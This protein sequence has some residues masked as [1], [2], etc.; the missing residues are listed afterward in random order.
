MKLNRYI[1]AQVRFWVRVSKSEGCWNWTGR[2]DQDGY[3]RLKVGGKDY[4]AHVYSYTLH[5]GAVP[6]GL[7]VLHKCDNRRCVRPDHLFLGTQE[8]NAADRVSKGRSA[9]GDRNAS[10]KYPERRPRGERHHWQT[11]PETRIR[12][13][14]NGRAKLTDSRVALIRSI[15][16]A[17]QH[18]KRGLGRMFGVSDTLINKIITNK[19]WTHL[20]GG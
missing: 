14:A 5:Y 10:R 6:A 11:K 12:G 18:T 9:F 19:L 15:W 4:G 3:G 20:K 1:P 17:G 16:S 2:P 7:C 13:E 8:D